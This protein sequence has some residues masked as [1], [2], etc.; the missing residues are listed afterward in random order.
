LPSPQPVSSNDNTS[1]TVYG[2]KAEALFKET[3]PKNWRKFRKQV[4]DNFQIMM[5]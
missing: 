3:I 5:Q 2:V 1:A 4:A